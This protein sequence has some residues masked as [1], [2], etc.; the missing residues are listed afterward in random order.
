MDKGA[1]SSSLTQSWVPN[2]WGGGAPRAGR[3]C[4]VEVIRRTQKERKANH[5]VLVCHYLLL[6]TG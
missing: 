6:L 4:G 2:D 5:I 3:T 1:V